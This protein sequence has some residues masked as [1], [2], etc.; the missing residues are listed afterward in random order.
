MKIGVDLRALQIG[1]QYRGIGEV[2]KRTLDGMFPLAINDGN[3]FVFYMYDNLED[4]TDLLHIPKNM[5]YEVVSVGQSPQSSQRTK[6]QKF[7][8][9]LTYLYGNP[10][11]SAKKCDV[12]L[13]YDYA[14]GVPTNVRTLL[15]KHDIIPFIFW[16]QFF[17][18]PMVPFKNRAARTTLRTIFHNY[19]SERS[20]TRAL[21]NAKK[22]VTVSDYTRQDIHEHFGT[23]LKKMQT[24]HL[25]V[26]P[27]R[28]KSV[29]SRSNAIMPT[30]PYLLFIGAVDKRRRRVD[31]LVSAFN[32]LKADGHDVQLV[33]VGENFQSPSSIPE[34]PVRKAVQTSSYKEDILTLGYINDATKESLF[35]GAL[36]F[37]FPSVYEG[38]GI[39]VLEAMSRGCPVIAYKNS[40]IPEVGGSH[41]LYAT[42][43]EGIYQHATRL[44]M[45]DASDRDTHVASAREHAQQFAWEKTAQELYLAVLSVKK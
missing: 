21:R 30:K 10:V 15:V 5:Q 41:A 18:S 3:S 7:S 31:E 11:K 39:P 1:H 29:A 42:G 17:E 16:D 43:W 33:L 19:R 44:L 26:A 38:F 13:Q 28:A 9:A 2:V 25:G 45:L 20:L 22:I 27:T 6:S 4:P 32:N 36:A 8:E 35:Q 24:V 34:G 40:S 14:L 12:F 37:V 23:S